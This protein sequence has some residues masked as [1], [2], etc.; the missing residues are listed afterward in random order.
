MPS[1]SRHICNFKIL[2]VEKVFRCSFLSYSYIEQDLKPDIG[3]SSLGLFHRE[4]WILQ[5][6]LYCNVILH[7][8]SS[9]SPSYLSYFPPYSLLLLTHLSVLYLSS[10]SSNELFILF[11]LSPSFLIQFIVSSFFF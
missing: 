10:V 1:F 9:P 11:L 2:L 4:I 3:L 6:Y 5:L 8:F 7:F